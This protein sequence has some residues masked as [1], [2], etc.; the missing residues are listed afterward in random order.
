[1]SWDFKERN[2][3]SSETTTVSLQSLKRYPHLLA[4]N[5]FFVQNQIKFQLKWNNSLTVWEIFALLMNN[6][7]LPLEKLHCWMRTLFCRPHL[8][9]DVLFPSWP[10]PPR[11]GLNLLDYT[12]EV[13]K[14]IFGPLFPLIL[15]F[16]TKFKTLFPVP[17]LIKSNIYFPTKWTYK[18][19][20]WN[21]ETKAGFLN[22]F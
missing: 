8:S 3:K 17:L 15:S 4:V 5:F 13:K 19:L 9:G 18:D 11:S 14:A 7:T 21:I 6:R 2:Q 10:T 20:M 22:V 12:F 16:I 1:M